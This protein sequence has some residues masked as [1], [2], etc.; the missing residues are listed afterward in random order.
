MSRRRTTRPQGD[1][2]SVLGDLRGSGRAGHRQSRARLLRQ[3]RA[4]S[5]Q[6]ARHVQRRVAATTRSSNDAGERRGGALIATLLSTM[7]RSRRPCRHRERPGSNCRGRRPRCGRRCLRRCR[8]PRATPTS[9]SRNHAARRRRRPPSCSGGTWT[10]SA[11]SSR[12][13][14]SSW[15]D[16]IR[17]AS[18]ETFRGSGSAGD[19]VARGGR[20]HAGRGDPDRD[21][22]RRD[23]PRPR[24]RSARS[25]SA[26][27]PIWSWSRAIRPR[28]SPTSRTS[29]SCSRT[30]SA[31]TPTNCW[32]P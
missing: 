25:P 24:R 22:E 18:M 7:S 6:E 32:S 8:R 31:T 26:R 17:S 9:M 13:A 15:L 23:L 19:R 5:R 21:L 27:M 11:R 2:P 20:L 30:A 29:R 14:A 16:R 1:R 28:A 3:H 4:R 12:R 10:W